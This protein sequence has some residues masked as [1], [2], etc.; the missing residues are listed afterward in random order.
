MRIVAEQR[1]RSADSVGGQVRDDA[2]AVPAD[3]YDALKK[4]S[5]TTA[6]ELVSFLST[7]PTAVS[8]ALHLSPEQT[9][10]AAGE[11]ISQLR[12]HV[13]DALLG[14]DVRFERGMGAFDP[15][16]LDR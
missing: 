11:L 1:Q 15:S 9:E 13:D 3:I 7:F 2:H 12:G 10:L 14:Q 16:D 8:E 5:V 6:E 4:L